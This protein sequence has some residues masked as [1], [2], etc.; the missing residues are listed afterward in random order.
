MPAIRINDVDLY[1]ETYGEGIPLVL[2]MGLRRNLEWWHCQIPAL[3]KHFKVVAFDNRGAG[4]SDKPDMEYSIPLFADDT[5]GLMEALEI[6]DAHILGI[7]MGGYI[8]QELALRHP[9]KVRSLILGCTSCG[10]SRAVLMSEERMKKF[11]A[12]EGLT[13]TEILR[14][15]MDIYFSDG[16]IAEHPDWI[17]E[18]IEISLRHYQPAYAFF[19][20]FSACLKHDTA[21]RLGGLKVPVFIMSGDD[22]PLVPPQNSLILKELLPSSKLFFFPACR[23]LFFIEEATEFNRKS[24]EFFRSFDNLP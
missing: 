5:A 12:N 13:P 8:A 9:D 1:Y 6:R 14:K 21:E 3:S 16:F 17:Q 4:R 22:D 11:T 7:S 2:I 19:R 10:G 23:H 15:D 20:Q 18:L 24:I